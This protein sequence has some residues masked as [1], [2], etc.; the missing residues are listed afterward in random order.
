MNFLIKN[1]KSYKLNT[2]LVSRINKSIILLLFISFTANLFAQQDISV[3]VSTLAG[4]TYGYTDGFGEAAQFD[5]PYGVAVDAQGTVYVADTFNHKIRKIAPNGEVSTLAGSSYG[6]AD[7]Q[8][9]SAKFNKPFG[10]AVDKQG[11]VYVADGMNFKIRKITPEGLVSTLAGSTKGFA[12]GTSEMAKFD[13]PYGVA[14]DAKG[15][16]YVAD[17]A[18]HI[19]VINPDGE[20]STIKSG[21]MVYGVAID[22]KDTV[23]IS[24]GRNHTIEE[25]IPNTS[26][27]SIAGSTKGFSDGSRYLA[28]FDTPFGLAKDINGNIYVSDSY[29]HRI[30]KIDVNGNISTI[31]GSSYGFADGSSSISK[32]ALP[33]GIAVDAKGNIY[34]ADSDNHKIRK[35]TLEEKLENNGDDNVNTNDETVLEEEN[36]D[37]TDDDLNENI[38][39]TGI[40]A[41]LEDDKKNR[42][43]FIFDSKTVAMRVEPESKNKEETMY[44]DK[45]GYVYIFSDDEGYIK[46]EF[47]GMMGMMSLPAP[48]AMAHSARIEQQESID[49]FGLDVRPKL[50]PLLEWAF[51]YKTHYF[52]GKPNINKQT[53][54]Y[55]GQS[56]CIKYTSESGKDAGSYIVFDSAGRLLKIVSANNEGSIVYTYQDND[57]QLPNAKTM[58]SFMNMFK[59][60]N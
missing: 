1:N 39:L 11:I 28:Q 42:M 17:G 29:N 47:Q 9:T 51:M 50:F 38:V 33:K 13:S 16:V 37:S 52:E 41:L 60:K 30:R 24:D 18:N 35:I 6:F 46:T 15:N 32:L 36:N 45:E 40:T 27:Q 54:N 55:Q 19:R 12:D 59:S 3:Q 20:V 22:L 49:Y 58:P 14:V 31:A 4:S 57:V 21:A 48:M 56:N 26:M 8:G 34:V 5:T 23:Y 53:V 43:Y 10:I 44:F 25:I 7:G 2:Y